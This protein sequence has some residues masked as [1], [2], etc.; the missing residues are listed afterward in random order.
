[1]TLPPSKGGSELLVEQVA[2]AWRPR[3]DGVGSHPAWHDLD[4]AGREDAHRVAVALRRIEAALDPDGLSSTARAV[5][6]VVR[7]GGRP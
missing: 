2:S 6:S 5:L 4:E 7:P 3:R 1:M